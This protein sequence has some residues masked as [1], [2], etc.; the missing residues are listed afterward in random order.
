[1]KFYKRA[2]VGSILLTLISTT[3]TSAQTVLSSIDSISEYGAEH[4]LEYLNGQVALKKAENNRESFILIEKTT[5]SGTG[6]LVQSRANAP[7]NPS[8]RSWGITGRIDIPLI[9]QLNISGSINQNGEGSAALYFKPL[10][11]SD[12][13]EQSHIT[14]NSALISAETARKEAES[15]A[16]KTALEWMYASKNYQ[17]QSLK[18]ELLGNMFLDD[19]IRFNLGE[20]TF[21]DLQDSMIIWSEARVSLSE[22]EK[23][24]RNAESSLYLALGASKEDVTVHFID[25]DEL[26]RAILQIQKELDGRTGDYMKNSQF[27]MSVLSRESAEVAFK[28]T[29]IYD[30]D[31]SVEA[32]IQFDENGLQGFTAAMTFSLSLDDLQAKEKEIS[33]EEYEIAS[34]QVIQSQN[35]AELEYKQ[36]LDKIESSNLNREI[37]WI[38]FEQAE[39]LY[40]EAQLLCKRGD[41]S[42]LDLEQSRLFLK[43][44]ENT[45]FK[46]FAD[47]YM[48][49]DSLKAYL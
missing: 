23:E 36:I 10:S 19:K 12:K 25:N 11:H 47:E 34:Q 43:A 4:S 26:E 18:T 3:A 49:W 46:A 39:I 20:I 38:E 31:L 2:L 17:T 1:M 37:A 6:D 35:E 48:A 14:Y 29:W 5:F 8:E 22:I 40:S 30:P 16:V 24:Y 33:R 27:K 28:N 42:E 45:L 32:S 13:R 7:E 9:E 21:E 41:I 44:S 15:M